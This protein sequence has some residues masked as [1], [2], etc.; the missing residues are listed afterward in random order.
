MFGNLEGSS[1]PSVQA[2]IAEFAVAGQHRQ[3]QRGRRRDRWRNGD[4]VKLLASLNP[5][6]GYRKPIVA[7][8][9]GRPGGHCQTQR[10]DITSPEVAS[11]DGA[12]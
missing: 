5:A 3:K 1:N 11:G 10:C 2:S 8:D 9:T 7:N 12:R 4:D 6:R